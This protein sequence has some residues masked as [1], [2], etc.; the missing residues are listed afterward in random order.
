MGK[1]PR[2]DSHTALSDCHVSLCVTAASSMQHLE[3]NEAGWGHITAEPGEGHS[4]YGSL[5]LI[6]TLGL[7]VS[8]MWLLPPIAHIRLA[9]AHV[10]VLHVSSPPR[11]GGPAN[12]TT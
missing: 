1:G 5:F 3:A 9:W 8:R 6:S 12:S 11:L 10:S 4:H 2:Q 7:T